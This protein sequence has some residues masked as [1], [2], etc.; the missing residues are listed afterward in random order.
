MKCEDFSPF[1]HRSRRCPSRRASQT[2]L[3]RGQK[4]A[5]K[6]LALPRIGAMDNHASSTHASFTHK[7]SKKTTNFGDN[8]KLYLYL[9]TEKKLH[10]LENA[11]RRCWF[12]FMA[13]M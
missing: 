1:P 12:K 10:T 13:T 9:T 4:S 2:T 6:S 8:L 5:D 11:S 7:M 3:E